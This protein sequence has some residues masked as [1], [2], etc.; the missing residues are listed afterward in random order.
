[1]N[2]NTT[3]AAVGAA[4][5]AAS[6]HGQVAITEFLNN[7]DGTDKGREW[8]ELFNYGPEAIHLLGWT[9]ADQDNDAI[10]LP[11]VTIA[12]GSYLMLVSGGV[13]GVGAAMAKVI[14]EVE[15]L[16]GAQSGAVIGVEGIVLANGADE[17]VLRDA[18]GSIIWSLAYGDDETSPFATFLADTADYTINV[19]GNQAEPGVVRD[20]DDNDLPGFLGY[21]E[22]DATPDPF[23]YESDVSD[24]AVLFGDDFAN[25]EEPSVG[26]PLLGGYHVGRPGDLDGDGKVGMND[27]LLLFAAWGPCPAPCPPRCAADL[28]GDC[29][30][31]VNDFFILHANWG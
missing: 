29:T 14:F 11:E 28:D 9:L 25:V 27:L 17:L 26:S 20:G 2:R 23:A 30:V 10:G 12:S 13:G 8:V 4:L 5:A 18:G 16:G 22:N 31:G 7:P 24:L 1:M 15:W 21:E 19:F 6:G 3:L